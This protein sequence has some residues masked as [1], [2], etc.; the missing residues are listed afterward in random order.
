MCA[1]SAGQCQS[2]SVIRFESVCGKLP[3]PFA[4]ATGSEGVL[5][6]QGDSLG[7]ARWQLWRSPWVPPGGF[8]SLTTWVLATQ[9]QIAKLIDLAGAGGQLWHRAGAGWLSSA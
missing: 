1:L 3:I 9:E 2:L 6:A 8:G 4:S 7:D 5:H